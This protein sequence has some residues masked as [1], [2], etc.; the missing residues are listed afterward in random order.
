MKNLILPVVLVLALALSACDKSSVAPTGP[1]NNSVAAV[2][3]LGSLDL[4]TDQELQLDQAFY[5]GEDLENTLTPRQTKAI[6]DLVIMFTP[7]DSMGGRIRQ[8]VMDMD[9]M[10]Y[11]RLILKANPDMSDEMK[12]AIYDL[13]VASAKNRLAI[14]LENKENPD[15]IRDLLKTEHEALIAAIN[16]LIGP[17]AVK[18]AE[19]LKAKIEQERKD[20]MEKLLEQRIQRQVDQLTK[21]LGL[22]EEQAAAI[23]AILIAQEKQI[24]ALREQ[25]KGDP[26]G[27]RAALKE[28]QAATD[29]A[30]SNLLTDEQLKKWEALKNRRHGGGGGPII[31]GPRG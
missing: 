22:D 31:I 18:N 4:T 2:Q 11:F 16:E 8:A 14:I 5:L 19:D 30:I 23:K 13:I 29:K 20:R 21:F 3:L 25:Y 17:E 27:F 6:N 26:E 28:L 12:K 1:T 7:P 9:A 10:M 15:V 24:Q